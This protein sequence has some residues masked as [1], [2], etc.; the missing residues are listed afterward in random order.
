MKK[1]I[2]PLLLTGLFFLLILL[3]VPS[4]CVYGSA[5]D[6]LSQHAALAETIRD[7]C[8]EQKTLLPDFLALGGGSSGFQFSYYGYLRPDILLG[9]LLPAVPMYQ[10]VILYSLAGYLAGVLLF[11]LWLRREQL[12]ETNAFLGSL[13]FLTASCFFHTH[14]QIMFVNYMPFLL[15]ALLSI[16]K[17]PRRMPAM[18]PVFLL[19]ICLLP[20]AFWL[21]AGTGCRNPAGL[22]SSPGSP[23]R[24]WQPAC[25]PPCCSPPDWPSWNTT[26]LPLPQAA[27]F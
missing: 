7:A 5:T 3:S 16:Q 13:L 25:Q 22:S 11:Y 23:P 9:C 21:Q 14:R 17:R 10:I 20:P 18:L 6:W 2:C 1:F 15:L 26:G 12:S 19:L 8:L 24:R 27:V 4:G